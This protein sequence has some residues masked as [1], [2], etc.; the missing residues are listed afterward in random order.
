LSSISK[1]EGIK[2]KWVLV[3]V[4][5]AMMPFA[6]GAIDAEIE[7]DEVFEQGDAVSFE[8]MINSSEDWVR[9]API[10]ICDN[11][12]QPTLNI[13]KVSTG[14]WHEYWAMKVEENTPSSNCSAIVYLVDYETSFDKRFLIRG[15]NLIDGEIFICAQ[16][17]CDMRQRVFNT[18]DV[19]YLDFSSNADAELNAYIYLPDGSSIG[20]EIPGSIEL[21]QRG[22]YRLVVKAGERDYVDRSFE[23]SFSVVEEVEKAEPLFKEE[24]KPLWPL[25]VFAGLIVLGGLLIWYGHREKTR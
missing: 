15:K 23:E 2:M 7:V 1:D 10:V 20:V 5:I 13:E 4:F 17:G 22:I 14:E 9:V 21:R 18:G 3:V 25:Y 6:F 16:P 24:E 11:V 8:Y 12:P 19:A